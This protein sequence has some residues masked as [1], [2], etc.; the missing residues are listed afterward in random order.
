MKQ[1][2]LQCI[3][4]QIHCPVEGN[5]NPSPPKEGLAIQPDKKLPHLHRRGRMVEKMQNLV[6]IVVHT[7]ERC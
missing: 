2:T 3:F 4:R 5:T 6:F 7:A 1:C